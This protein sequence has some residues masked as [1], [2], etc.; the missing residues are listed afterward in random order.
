MARQQSKPAPDSRVTAEY[1]HLWVQGAVK[2]ES[3]GEL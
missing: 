2:K 1:K 3:G